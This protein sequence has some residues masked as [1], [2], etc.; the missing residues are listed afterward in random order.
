MID[1]ATVQRI[2]DAV[3]IVEVVQDFVSL[4]KNGT[5]YK[6]LCPF[7]NEKTPS[8]LV[9]PAK[10]I[11]KCFG[12]GEG[13]NAVN[14]VMSHE[15]LTYPDALKYLAKKYHIEIEEKELTVE[16]IENH[17]ERESLLIVNGFAQRFFSKNLFESDEGQSVGLSYFKERAFKEETLKAFD[18]G[19]CPEGWEHFTQAALKQ[20]YKLDYL[21]KTGLT[22]QRESR[23]FD[24]FHG[25]VMFPIHA[26]SGKVLGF[27]GRT[28]KTDKKIA[29]YLNSPESPVYNK[30]QV[31]YG[32]FQA[33]K[34]MV[35]ENKCY[36]VEGYTDVLALHQAG[37]K[38]VVA[39]SG[40]ALTSG[41]IRL[42]RRFTKELTILYDGDQAGI[43]A[44]LRGTDLALAE[45][46]NVRIVRLPEGEDPD[47][48]SKQMSGLDLKRY[49]EEQETDFISFKT[50]LLLEEAEEDPVRR[51]GL[52]GDVVRS[53]AMIPDKML[54][55]EYV[56]VCSRMLDVTE[57]L[58]YT[59]I[60]KTL[61]KKDE[62][63]NKQLARQQQQSRQAKVNTPP[64]P[65][66]ID[67][68]FCEAIEKEIIRLLL[69]Y[70]E[71]IFSLKRKDDEQ[72][73]EESLTV[74][75]YIIR[76]MLNDK[77]EFKNLVYKQVFEDYRRLLEEGKDVGP[78]HF[79]NYPDKRIGQLCSD[80]LSSPYDL[81]KYW[82][83]GGGFITTED[84][85]LKK[86]VPDALLT[87][88]IK[89]IELARDDLQKQ[90][91]T[92]TDDLMALLSKLKVL[93]EYRKALAEAR[94]GLIILR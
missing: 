81:S 12:C 61:R 53:V 7:H 48:F 68:T 34:S 15:K 66:F 8:F 55:S 56:K 1:E 21:V 50:K 91:K 78:S 32:I 25:R 75:D 87:Y 59:E 10:G 42:I 29:K 5:N 86:I 88:K 60:Q 37:V 67:H 84:Q 76:E 85:V 80:L 16:E 2:F 38:N 57:D 90:L 58:L 70:G 49:L 13:G 23:R 31:L 39:S 74:S 77:L 19:Y 54:R 28:L 3:D 47:S 45:E 41:Q 11:Y 43:K 36:L 27:G 22:I 18:L 62:R 71:T 63:Y 30:S 89:V 6:G 94:G 9:S 40:T 33:K 26:L 79:V 69:H 65:D 4:K 51:A 17:N 52:V 44:S 35:Q 14:F 20:G 82:Q 64:I 83:R 92:Q 73:G 93:D 24:R 46:M 72:D